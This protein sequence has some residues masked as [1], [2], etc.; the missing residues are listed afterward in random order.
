[1]Q[2]YKRKH[3][4]RYPSPA[5]AIAYLAARSRNL[6]TGV[7]GCENLKYVMLLKKFIYILLPNDHLSL[8]LTIPVKFRN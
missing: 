1:M 6:K 4:I 8:V 5:K 3:L 2:V 7:S